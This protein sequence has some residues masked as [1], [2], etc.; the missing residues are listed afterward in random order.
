[1]LLGTMT[2][3]RVI[4]LTKKTSDILSRVFAL[5]VNSRVSSCA[6]RAGQCYLSPLAALARHARSAF[7][8]VV[9]RRL[10]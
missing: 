10:L 5:K 9:L 2:C 4:V 7:P 1:M 6:R 8:F 3:L